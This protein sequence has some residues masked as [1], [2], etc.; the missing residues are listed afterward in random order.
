MSAESDT[1]HTTGFGIDSQFGWPLG[2]TLGGIIGALAF[3]SLIWLFDPEIVRAAIP[4]IYGF[5]ATGL[6]GWGIHLVHG[7]ILGLVFGFLVTREF[8]LGIIRTGA[9]TDALENRSD[10]ARVTAAG[11]VYG[12]A[13]WAILPV[14]ALPMWT[15]AA[16]AEAAADFPAIAVESMIGHLIFGLV[17]GLVFATTVDLHDR[18]TPEPLEE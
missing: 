5:E 10:W 8:I 3:G 15:A 9:E 4:G 18:D 13:I 14:I 7:A 1:E 12:L 17:L 16:G 6:Y 2:G 11:F